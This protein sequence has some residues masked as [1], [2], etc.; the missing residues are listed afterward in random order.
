M[1]SVACDPAPEE[2]NEELKRSWHPG[3]GTRRSRIPRASRCTPLRSRLG[4]YAICPCVA[5]LIGL[6]RRDR[7]PYDLCN[8]VYALECDLTAGL[9]DDLLRERQ[10]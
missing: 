4:Q 6:S 10:P 2:K 3:H 1:A 5:S 8:P 9:F 7:D